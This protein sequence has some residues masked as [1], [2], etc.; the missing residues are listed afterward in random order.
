MQ[1]QRSTT[2]ICWVVGAN[3]LVDVIDG[4]VHRIWTNMSID[5]MLQARKGVFLV[6]FND[7]EDKMIVIQR[8]I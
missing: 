4:F 3:P 6:R 5:E 8:E 1:V 2:V 7:I